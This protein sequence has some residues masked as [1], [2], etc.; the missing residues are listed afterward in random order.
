MREAEAIR[1][2]GL[3]EADSEKA[4]AEA[5]AAFD[6]VAQRVELVRLELD[7]KMRIEIA[8][9]DAFGKAVASMDLKLIGDPNAA[10]SLLRLVTFSDGLGEVIKAAPQPVQEMGRSLIGRLTN[11]TPVVAQGDNGDGHSA[12]LAELAEMVPAFVKLV[13]K[14]FEIE[15][16]AKMSVKEVLAALAD[17][18][19]GQDKALVEKAQKAL[20]FLPLINDLP[21]EELYLR[22]GTPA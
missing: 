13:E 15:D 16:L 17:E 10:A 14:T 2:R 3:A 4:R 11:P 5:L 8:R 22:A 7:A 9:A 20:A 18:V 1:A 6:G 21:F 19:S 12:G